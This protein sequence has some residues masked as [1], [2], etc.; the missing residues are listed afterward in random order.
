MNWQLKST[1]VEVRQN[2]VIDVSVCAW[3]NGF[4]S[5]RLRFL[6]CKVRLIIV[7][8]SQGGS[9]KGLIQP[10]AQG[11]YALPPHNIQTGA[12]PSRISQGARDTPRVGGVETQRQ[13]FGH[14]DYLSGFHQRN[15]AS[16]RSP[17]RALLQRIGHVIVGT[18]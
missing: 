1:H 15:R 14:T 12:H 10:L 16:G 8:T 2:G 18:G 4:S 11:L 3:G 17:V 6:L 5:L 9:Q 13:I 7:P